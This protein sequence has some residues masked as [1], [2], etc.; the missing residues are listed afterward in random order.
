MPSPPPWRQ[1]WHPVDPKNLAPSARD[2]RK[3]LPNTIP[4]PDSA[5]SSDSTS[6]SSAEFSRDKN[7][8]QTFRLHSAKEQIVDAVNAALYLR[9][10]LLVTGRPGTG[11]TSLAYAIG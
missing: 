5:S 2:Y 7:R 9:R 11:K 6:N 3:Q 1:F 10:P 8:G 4:I